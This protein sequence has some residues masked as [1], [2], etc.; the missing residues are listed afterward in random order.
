MTETWLGAHGKL[1]YDD[2]WYRL[3]WLIWPQALAMVLFLL[4]WATPSQRG[5]QWAK[6]VDNH[7]R[8]LELQ[9]LRD[10]AI[11]NRASMDALERAASGGEMN[12]QFYF[13]TLY[14]P[15]LKLSKIVQP[16]V[17]KAVDW[18][19]K[20]ANQGEVVAL[21]N[22]ALIYSTGAYARV[23]YARSCYYALKTT[24]DSPAA[25]LGVK[26]DCYARGLGGT[27][28]D[29]TQAANAYEA[30]YSKGHVRSGAKLGY[31]F[32]NGLGG[33]VRSNET[34]LKY[35]RAAADKNDALGLHNLGAAYGGGLLGLPRDG[36]EA[37]RLIML[38]LEAKYDVTLQ[39][40]TS[41]PENWT[42][43]FW[44]NLQRRMAE[45]GYYSGIADGRPNAATLDAVRRFGS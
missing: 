28:T 25:S 29:M 26:G 18:Y 10:A 9:K 1:W 17:V 11:N 36:A 23:D 27:R 14:A 7:Q 41:R 3:S 45:R 21:G 5:S 13:A 2:K 34:A 22:L 42:A 32:E 40:L 43:D 35:Y 39:S 38:A 31:F 33:R 30:A 8:A 15:D 44:Q 12:A 19:T 37:A 16:D 4:F 6:P 20:A 24:S